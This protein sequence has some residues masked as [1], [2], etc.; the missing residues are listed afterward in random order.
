MMPLDETV[1][2]LNA[3][4][5]AVGAVGLGWCVFSE[6]VRDGVVIKLGLVLM[7]LSLGVTAVELADGI[8]CTDLLPLNRARLLLY[9]G[10]AI[11][12]AGYRW[13]LRRGETLRDVLPR[14]GCVRQAQAGAERGGR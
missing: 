12:A 10:V 9:A 1:A 5:S 8:Q 6:R 2:Y 13:R 14:R 7:S 3:A 11:V 4:A